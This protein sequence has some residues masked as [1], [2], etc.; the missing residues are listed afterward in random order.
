MDNG[1]NTV[2]NF[3]PEEFLKIF[4]SADARNLLLAF[5]AR[6]FKGHDTDQ[7]ILGLVYDTRTKEWL[8]ARAIGIWF[9]YISW[10]NDRSTLKA[11]NISYP[12]KIEVMSG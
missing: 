5:D 12:K 9:K 10:T 4:L 7:T 1:S 3:V 6:E 2:D 11:E 8:P